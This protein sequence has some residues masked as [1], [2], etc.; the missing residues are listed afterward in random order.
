MTTCE[1]FNIEDGVFRKTKSSSQLKLKITIT[2]TICCFEITIDINFFD[3]QHIYY[4]IFFISVII[5]YN[6]IFKS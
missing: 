6:G 2:F 5:I 3:W 1:I 4:N